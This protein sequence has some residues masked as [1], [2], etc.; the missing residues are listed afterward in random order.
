[1]AAFREVAR[2]AAAHHERLDDA[3]YHRGLSADQLGLPERILAVADVT[4]ALTADRPYRAA[5]P[6]DQALR[7]LRALAGS[8]TCPRCQD[9]LERFL[10]KTG[11]DPFRREPLLRMV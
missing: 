6:W 7:R 11:F 3:G 4:E 2:V 5:M 1:M 9:G 10:E 8:A